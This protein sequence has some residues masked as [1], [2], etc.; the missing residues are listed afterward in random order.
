MTCDLG[1]FACDGSVDIFKH[2]EI[3]GEENVKVSLVDLWEFC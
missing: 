2:V 1:Q 3:G